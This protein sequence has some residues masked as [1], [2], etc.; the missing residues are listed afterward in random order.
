MALI[1]RQLFRR[2][3]RLGGDEP[4][5]ESGGSSGV[6]A[7]LGGA[8]RE[9]QAEQMGG[10]GC[11]DGVCLSA[12]KFGCAGDFGNAAEIVAK[13]GVHGAD[14]L[15]DRERHRCEELQ[16]VG[17]PFGAQAHHA[18]VESIG[19]FAWRE[20]RDIG[21]ATWFGAGSCRRKR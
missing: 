6:I 12:R 8:D 1:F 20:V 15:I 16:A 2:F 7:K 5:A 4:A 19:A 14:A 10:V 21:R 9:H 18:I 3:D 13:I 17:F 11:E